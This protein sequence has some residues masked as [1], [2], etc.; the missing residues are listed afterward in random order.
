MSLMHLIENY[1]LVNLRR[2]F[3]FVFE[4]IFIKNR[5]FDQIFE[6]SQ[7]VLEPVLANLYEELER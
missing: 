6:I 5:L 3:F 4:K 1:F 7:G 2:R